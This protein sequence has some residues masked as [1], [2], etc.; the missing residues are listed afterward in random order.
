MRDSPPAAW[1]ASPVYFMYPVVA[2]VHARSELNRL[3]SGWHV[4]HVVHNNHRVLEGHLTIGSWRASS[5][6]NDDF[7]IPLVGNSNH[8]S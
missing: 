6:S 2:T 4:R 1:G 3:Q 5:T 7:G 8:V